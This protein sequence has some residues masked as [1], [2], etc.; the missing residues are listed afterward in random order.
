MSKIDSDELALLRTYPQSSRLYLGVQQG[1]T[2]LTAQVDGDHSEGDTTILLKNVVYDDVT[3]LLRGMTVSIGAL[4]TRNRKVSAVFISYDSGT[5]TLTIGP[6]AHTAHDDDYVTVYSAF[7]LW[8]M[9]APAF[10]T[11]KTPPFAIM[12]P[13]RA[14]FVDEP[15]SFTGDNSYSPVGRELTTFLWKKFDADLVDGDLNAA[16]DV[17]A[18]LVLSWDTAGEYLVK[19]KVT[20]DAGE[21]GVSYRP[22]L[23]YDRTGEN[24][25]Y[26]NFIIKNAR[27]NGKGWSADF[28]VYDTATEE[29][30]PPEALVVVWAENWYGATKQNIGGAYRGASEILFCG[31]IRDN[32]VKA[33]ADDKS[34]RFTLDSIDA[35][36]ARLTMPS[37]TF[38]DGDDTTNWTTFNAFTLD[39]AA[40][41]II[42]QRTTLSLMAD[43]FMA[44]FSFELGI[45]DV[46]EASLYEQ[47]SQSIVPA[48]F[49]Y[50]AAS[51]FASVTIARDRNVLTPGQRAYFNTASIMLTSQDW[52]ELTVGKE[53]FASLARVRLEGRLA[54][55]TPVAANYPTTGPGHSG[56]IK[57]ISGLVFANAAQCEQLAQRMYRK[58]NRRIK[59]VSLR[60][61]NY[62]VLE[63]AF[64]EYFT[65]ILAADENAAGYT[66]DNELNGDTGREFVCSGMSIEFGEGFLMVS[67]QG[68]A[69]AYGAHGAEWTP[70]D[71]LPPRQW[72]AGYGQ[73]PEGTITELVG[74]TDDADDALT[75]DAG[76]A[77]GEDV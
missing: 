58:G 46:P 16:N 29:D 59:N 72:L 14:G 54:D 77:L 73:G 8:K 67:V 65:V 55:D 3:D 7:H 66:W 22:A 36:M 6:N 74:L 61:P 71:P 44:L 34:V 30:F 56:E 39:K 76:L 41:H 52:L 1:T 48:V 11:Q 12:G 50:V 42:Q 32:S 43:V 75:D 63:P 33:N 35:V 26:Q 25:P 45:L 64:Q 40:L 49:G 15:L 18:P 60:M 57:T 13:P 24:A 2:I 62:C 10:T 47:L 38:R 9:D 21:V 53:S 68:E 5:L 28:T 37:F 4:E 19:L 27:Y 23:I 69:S 17:D 20:D 70:L 51:R 31:W